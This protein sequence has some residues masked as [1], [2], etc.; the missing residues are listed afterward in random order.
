VSATG[1]ALPGVFSVNVTSLAYAQRTY[2]NAV[3]S[4][5]EALG[6]TGTLRLAVG[7]TT[8]DIA[9]EASDTLQD[10]VTKI[11]AAGIQVSAAVLEQGSEAR[12]QLRGLGT[13]VANAITITEM[14]D[15]GQATTL[16]GLSDPANTYQ[17]ATDAVVEIDGHAVTRSSNQINDAIP[18]VTLA[19][20]TANTSSTI[21]ID[22][23]PDTLKT[24][25][26]AVVSAYN[27][28]VSKVHGLAGYGTVQASNTALAGDSTLR[29]LTSGLSSVLLTR[30]GEGQFDSLSSLGIKQNSD[31]TLTLDND[32]LSAAVDQDPTGV[33]NLLAGSGSTDGVM[34][35]LRTTVESFT[36][37]T[38]GLLQNHKD[39]LT[40]RADSLT[41][42][43]E[44][45]QDRLD[46]YAENLR[47]QFTAM[48]TAVAAYQ[49]QLTYLQK[50]FG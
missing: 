3:S 30:V 34:D 42:R 1:A 44:H 25:V 45:E 26:E 6:K 22:S 12:L 23:D 35:V 10:V 32:K 33:A 50:V 9:L 7:S 28:V 13:G 40:S 15:Q 19:I 17:K 41:D 31:G 20:T 8:E 47:K 16:L 37:A 18:G 43:I 36:N 24:R 4:S 14:D 5:S 21:T 48:D 11:N 38:S 29:S 2:S 39:G 27:A 49:S 46:R